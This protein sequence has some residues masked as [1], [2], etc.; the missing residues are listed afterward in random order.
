MT[1]SPRPWRRSKGGYA[2]GP[3]TVEKLGPPPSS[4]GAGSISEEVYSRYRDVLL[5]TVR[6]VFAAA[7][8]R[9]DPAVEDVLFEVLM[10]VSRREPDLSGAEL[11]RY[12]VRMARWRALDHL[13]R[14]RRAARGA[15]E[16]VSAT[17]QQGA[18][19]SDFEELAMSRLVVEEALRSLSP[20]EAEAL[21]KRI[22]LGKSQA[23]V[24]GEM[25]L[26]EAALRALLRRS[27]RRLRQQLLDEGAKLTELEDDPQ[28]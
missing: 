4:A 19:A 23:E 11:R 2:S 7:G 5:E 6:H 16:D 8:R 10:E 25:G 20:E 21:W 1:E 13:R 12:V 15:E 14:Q 9:D 27:M 22:A 24:A 17:R 18:D 3:T 28:A 26:S